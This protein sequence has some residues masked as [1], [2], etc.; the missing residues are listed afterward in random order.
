[1]ISFR[2]I[3]YNSLYKYYKTCMEIDFNHK[4]DKNEEM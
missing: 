3:D 1:M 2:I 4:G